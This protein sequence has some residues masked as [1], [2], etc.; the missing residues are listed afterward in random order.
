VAAAGWRSGREVV[1]LVMRRYRVQ[2]AALASIGVLALWLGCANAPEGPPPQGEAPQAQR[3]AA[4]VFQHRI[5]RTYP[6]DR[7]A[8]TQGLVFRDG[9]LYEST[10]LYG[11]SSLRKVAL[12]TGQVV[13]EKTVAREYFAEGLS[14]WGDALVQLTWTSGLALVYDRESF[15]ETRRFAYSGEGWGLTKTDRHLV[16]SDGSATLRLLDP[17]TFAEVSRVKVHDENGPV[18][19]LNELEMVRGT[20]FANVWQT[21][22]IAMI[23]LD[24]GAVTGW[25]DLRGLLSASERAQT[26]VLNGIAFDEGGNRLFVTGK[27]WP[28]LFQIEVLR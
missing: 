4:R 2:P 6:H 11:Q 27:W 14:E 12:E 18:S 19:A 24:S 10:G 21:E 17:A 23:A 13:R 8:F 28:R 7:R 22:R 9:F 15:K 20:L 5:V 16:M 25:L 3:A 26:D 1:P